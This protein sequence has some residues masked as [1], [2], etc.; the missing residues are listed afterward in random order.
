MFQCWKPETLGTTVHGTRCQQHRMI[1]LNMYM[2]FRV[3]IKCATVLCLQ[4]MNNKNNGGLKQKGQTKKPCRM[5]VCA[6]AVPPSVVCCQQCRQCHLSVVHETNYS[7]HCSDSPARITYA[8]RATTMEW[9][10]TMKNRLYWIIIYIFIVY[11]FSK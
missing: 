9:H 7:L 2:Y 3:W 1:T 8:V 6:T 5:C 10:I 4:V 11:S